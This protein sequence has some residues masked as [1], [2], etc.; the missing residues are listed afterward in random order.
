MEL[1]LAMNWLP[2]EDKV[3]E[4]NFDSTNFDSTNTHLLSGRNYEIILRL[5]S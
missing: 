1:N 3:N 2:I 5:F 4:I